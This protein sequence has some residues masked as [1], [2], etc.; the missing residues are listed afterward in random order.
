MDSECPFEESNVPPEPRDVPL[1]VSFFGLG[2]PALSHVDER[3]RDSKKFWLRAAVPN[4]PFWFLAD[5]GSALNIV[6]KNFYFSLPYHPSPAPP[7][8]NLHLI[9]GHNAV[10]PVVEEVV[11]PF[12]LHGR[13]FYHVFKII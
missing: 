10:L 11:L 8:P 9:S 2:V 3:H 7:D 6:D 13:Q 12:T 1:F 5:T 4:F